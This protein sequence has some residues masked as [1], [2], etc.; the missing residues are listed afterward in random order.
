ML[1]R[2]RLELALAATHEQRLGPD[3]VP[4]TDGQPALL[5]DGEDGTDEMLVHPHPAG[6]PVHDDADDALTHFSPH[7]KRL[8]RRRVARSTRSRNLKRDSPSLG[9]TPPKRRR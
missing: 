7:G 6:D 9:C 4:A 1:L 8:P 5:A 2:K 3:D